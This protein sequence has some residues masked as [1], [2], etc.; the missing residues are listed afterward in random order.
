MKTCPIIIIAA[1]LA[2]AGSVNATVL[3]GSITVAEGGTQVSSFTSSSI[4]MNVTNLVVRSSG[5]FSGLVPSLSQLMANDTSISGLSS[6]PTSEPVNNYLV[7]SSSD[8]Y[9]GTGTAPPYR[10]EFEL[11]S[12]AEVAYSAPDFASFVGTGTLIDT[13]GAYE[14]TP[15]TFNLSFSSPTSYSFSLTATPVPEPTTVSLFA[16]GIL[17]ALALRRRK[18]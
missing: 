10:F 15:A 18:I 7:F 3:T 11:T 2:L 13:S 6:T 1:N 4:S 14:S 12:L 16:A 8:A 9:S 17:G 5:D